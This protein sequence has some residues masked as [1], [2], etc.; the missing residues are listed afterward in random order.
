MKQLVAAILGLAFFSGGALGACPVGKKE[1]DTWCEKG[2]EW[3]CDRCASQ[4][5]PIIT[6]RSCVKDD[7]ASLPATP[8]W[9]LVAASARSEDARGPV[10]KAR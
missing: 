7:E 10:L 2:M 4:Y 1:G 3:R 6:G 5:C 9:R 8:L